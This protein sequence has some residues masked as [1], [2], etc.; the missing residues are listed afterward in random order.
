MPCGNRQKISGSSR[1]TM[2][3]GLLPLDGVVLPDD[4][5]DRPTGLGEIPHLVFL[6]TLYPVLTVTTWL[7]FLLYTPFGVWQF[8]SKKYKRLIKGYKHQRKV[9]KM[10][11][12]AHK[13]DTNVTDGDGEGG[14]DELAPPPTGLSGG[15]ESM[16]R[17]IGKMAADNP[18]QFLKFKK[19]LQQAHQQDM[20]FLTTTAFSLGTF[21]L[22]IAG[23]LWYVVLLLFVLMLWSSVYQWG[24]KVLFSLYNVLVRPITDM[25]RTQRRRR[26]VA[27]VPQSPHAAHVALAMHNA[28]PSR[29]LAAGNSGPATSPFIFFGLRSNRKLFGRPEGQ[30]QDGVGE[31]VLRTR[32]AQLHWRHAILRVIAVKN[33]RYMTKRDIL[34]AM[35]V[36][37]FKPHMAGWNLSVD[38]RKNSQ[39]IMDEQMEDLENDD[40]AWDDDEF[41]GLGDDDTMEVGVFKRKTLLVHG[42]IP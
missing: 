15:R 5:R 11:Q 23:L 13:Q 28:T 25:F 31:D 30:Q 22:T 27:P 24:A 42:L 14:Q 19:A 34:K 39:D 37:K 41:T 7:L 36:S 12:G 35:A 17:N 10:K 3:L 9:A 4:V 32:R 8:A 2:K 26:K 1:H 16:P 33:E 21:F 20:G 38:P 29:I 40:D 6:L 18:E